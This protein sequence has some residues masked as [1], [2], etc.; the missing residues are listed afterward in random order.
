VNPVRPLASLLADLIFSALVC[1]VAAVLVEVTARLIQ[2]NARPM[3]P[4]VIDRLGATRL[5]AD[6]DIPIQLPHYAR[7]RLV[8]DGLGARVASVAARDAERTGGVLFVGDSQILGWGLAFQQTAAARLAGLIGVPREKVAIVA[9]PAE[10]PEKEVG[11]A[12]DYARL[13]PERQRVE[14]VALNL[15]NDLEEI[16]LSRAGTLFQSSGGLSA[17]LSHH[18]VAYLDLALLRSALWGQQGEPHPEVNS[19]MRRLDDEERSLLAAD[20]AASLER[21]FNELPPADQRIV[22]IIPQDS[23]VR[24]EEFDKYRA[25][26]SDEADFSLHKAAQEIAVARLKEFQQMGAAC[27]RAAGLTVVLLEPALREAWRKT[28]LIDTRSHHLMAAGQE[29][30]ARAVAAVMKAAQ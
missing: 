29:I 25:Y 10:D 14:V 5:E 22:M 11:W 12:R 15:G 30:A 26:Y 17:W 6:L 27:L 21:L 16:Y 23:Q 4:F 8:T 13:R 2:V 19:A 24:I 3:I 18:S 7:M 20:V 1:V 28:D 9:A